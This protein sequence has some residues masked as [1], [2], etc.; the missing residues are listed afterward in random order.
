MSMRPCIECGR[1]SPAG[2][3]PLHPKPRSPSS[4]ASGKYRHK[5]ARAKMRTGH[6]VCWICGHDILRED[7]QLDH[8]IPVSKGGEHGPTAPAHSFCNESRGN[9]AA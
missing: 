8:L 1:L 3:C 5:K 6:R 9:H 4:V 2:R 7:A